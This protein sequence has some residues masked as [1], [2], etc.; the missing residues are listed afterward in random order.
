MFGYRL[1]ANTMSAE[2]TWR[3]SLD[4]NQEIIDVRT[5]YQSISSATKHEH[6]LPTVFG[7]DGELFYKY[8]D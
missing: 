8:L 4:A 5:Q 7:F 2:N 3:I 1:N 6:V